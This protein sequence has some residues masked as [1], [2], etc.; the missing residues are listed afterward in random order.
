MNVIRQLFIYICDM[1]EYYKVLWEGSIYLSHI[2]IRPIYNIVFIQHICRMK[3]NNAISEEKNKGM[4]G[5]S[6]W[7]S[8]CSICSLHS[9]IDGV[10]WGWI[11]SFVCVFNNNN[12]K[13]NN[14]DSYNSRTFNA[15]CF[16]VTNFE[17]P[18]KNITASGA[19]F[20][21]RYRWFER[22]SDS[23]RK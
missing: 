9:K 11:C 21:W 2:D 18:L 20:R 1:R 22:I 16:S 8:L 23:G 13:N 12:N 7:F 14:R 17:S 10:L 19:L 4:R 6:A 3:E 15:V 5:K